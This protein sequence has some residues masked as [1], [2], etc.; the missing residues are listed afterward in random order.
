MT[1]VISINSHARRF[2]PGSVA[3][4]RRHGWCE[5][6]SAQDTRRTIRW[7]T[8]EPDAVPDTTD[9]PADVLPEEVLMS[10]T[11]SVNVDEVDAEELTVIDKPHLSLHQEVMQHLTFIKG[12]LD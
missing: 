10:E 11:I 2:P 3:M 1:N 5:V 12:L 6:V 8:Y 9:L 7:L 4:H